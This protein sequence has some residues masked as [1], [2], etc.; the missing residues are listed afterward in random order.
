VLFSSHQLDLVERLG[1]RVGIIKVGSMV[2]IASIDELR[3]RGGL[4]WRLQGPPA[5]AGWPGKVPGA[6]VVR[7]ERPLTAVELDR[8]GRADDSGQEP[9]QAALT[10]GPVHAFAPCRPRLVELHRHAVSDSTDPPTGSQ[11][12]EGTRP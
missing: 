11:A 1:D 2:A 3:N 6:R 8:Q 10:V 7:T 5:A 9:L 12:G 4:R